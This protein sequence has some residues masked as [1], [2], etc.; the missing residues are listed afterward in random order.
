MGPGPLDIGEN[1]LH[2]REHEYPAIRQC[3]GLVMEGA[4]LPLSQSGQLLVDP[5]SVRFGHRESK[6][7]RLT[8]N[9]PGVD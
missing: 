2:G 6:Q 1:L 9:L 5:R 7:A 3:P 4:D 8:D